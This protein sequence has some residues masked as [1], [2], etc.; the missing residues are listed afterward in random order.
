M[1]FMD[2]NV[3]TGLVRYKDDQSGHPCSVTGLNVLQAQPA[4]TARFPASL[5]FSQGT[6]QLL[7]NSRAIAQRINHQRYR[8][9]T[10]VWAAGCVMCGLW[11]GARPSC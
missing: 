8:K 9:T 11:R 3:A 10:W 5:L 2:E 7:R 6:T 1:R 4:C